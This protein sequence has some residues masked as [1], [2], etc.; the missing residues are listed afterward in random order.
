MCETCE[1]DCECETC[2]NVTVNVSKDMLDYIA[3][4]LGYVVGLAIICL[5]QA[6]KTNLIFL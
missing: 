5:R 2:V 6:N 4:L 3:G 1:F